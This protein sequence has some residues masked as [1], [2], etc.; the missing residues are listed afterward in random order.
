MFLKMFRSGR[1]AVKKAAPAVLT[2][3]A[4]PKPH[5]FNGLFNQSVQKDYRGRQE[6]VPFKA[7]PDKPAKPAAAVAVKPVA[8]TKS[9]GDHELQAIRATCA[10]L[11][12]NAER[13][14][15]LTSVPV[16]KASLPGAPKPPKPT[17]TLD[18]EISNLTKLIGSS[19]NQHE[20]VSLREQL[21]AK[22]AQRDAKE[23]V[24]I[25]EGIQKS[26]QR[27]ELALARGFL[28]GSAHACRI[29]V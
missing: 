2:L 5:P 25:R 18:E 7:G 23:H 1:I 11:L 20:I 15:E 27:N 6:F 24:A 17:L 22:C 21:N 4:G 3:D 28:I 12:A 10:E 8:K 16:Q 29:G 19:T 13:L 14:K 9:K 26:A